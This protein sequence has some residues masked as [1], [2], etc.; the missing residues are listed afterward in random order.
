MSNDSITLQEMPD[1]D[2]AR[3]AAAPAAPSRAHSYRDILKSSAMVGASAS[4]NVLIGMVRTKCMALMLG[5]AGYGIMGAFMQVTDLARVVAQVGVNGSGVR[6]IADAAGTQDEAR[7]GRTVAAV[8][9]LS[10]GCGVIGAVLTALLA[11]PISQLAFGNRD[12]VTDIA[13]LSLVVLFSVVSTGQGAVLQGL[14]RIADL[15]KLTVV[16]G[17]AGTCVAVPLVYFAGY[18]AI[19]PALV[20]VALVSAL[21][22]WHFCRRNH[23]MGTR[24]TWTDLR[25][26]SSGLLKLGLAF[27]ASGLVSTAA[28]FAVRTL[29]LRKAGLDAAGMYYAAWTLGGLYIG[30]VIQALGTD[31]YPRLV[32]ANRDDAECNR[33]VNEQAVV[34]LLL[35]IPGVLFTITLAPLVM[36]LF[37]SA[38]FAA[39]VDVL[40]WICLGMALRVFTWPMGFI[41]VA[42]NR[43][44][45][46]FVIE[47]AWTIFN[48]SATWLCVDLFGLNGAGIAFLASYA[49]HG[50]VTYPIARSLSGF[51]WSA[52]NLRLAAAGLGVLAAVFAGFRWLPPTASLLVGV[53]ASLSSSYISLR[54]L[55]RLASPQRLPRPIARILQ[56]RSLS[57]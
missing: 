17:V 4:A 38:S 27:L 8:Q 20:V 54:L 46:F 40:R 34:S 47:T 19:A 55:V 5:P 50:L 24:L 6:Q 3:P 30:F 31:F 12:H 33:L 7:I 21:A 10:L 25:A 49:F 36:S 14:R 15:S 9:A 22:S 48:V 29:V 57:R 43:Q 42:K 28:S 26:E 56:L 44:M 51:R 13:L 23:A 37:Y 18:R 1:A 11:G 35:A 52:G 32:G 39:A 16:G 41:V 2:P 53:V 45:L